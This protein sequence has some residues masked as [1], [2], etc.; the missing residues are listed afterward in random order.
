[1]LSDKNPVNQESNQTKNSVIKK[2]MVKNK[3]TE[4]EILIHLNF[5]KTK[6]IVGLWLWNKC[7]ITLK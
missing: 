4:D 6:T 1:M 3:E 2:L 5:Y 7:K